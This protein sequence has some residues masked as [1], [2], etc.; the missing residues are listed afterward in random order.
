MPVAAIFDC[1]IRMARDWSSR[2]PAR[3]RP[4][5]KSSKL[6]ESTSAS[7]TNATTISISVN[8]PSRFALLL[9]DRHPPRDPVHV[10]EVLALAG[11]NGDAAAR[12]AA[13]GIEPDGADALAHHLRLRGVELEV[14]LAGDGVRVQVGHA[15]FARFDVHR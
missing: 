9:I 10:H 14:H 13:I 7:S 4:A 6:V 8:P 11:G 5:E 1:A 3:R 12:R 15:E 2:S